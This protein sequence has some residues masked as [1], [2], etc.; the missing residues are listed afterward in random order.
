M[1]VD[2]KGRRVDKGP[3]N[4]VKDPKSKDGAVTNGISCMSCHARGIIDKPDQI[5]DHVAKNSG[6]FAKGEPELIQAIYPERHK[7]A[8]LVQ[9]DAERFALAVRATGASPGGTDPVVELAS[10]YEYDLDAELAAAEIGLPRQ[11]FLDGLNRSTDLSRV[12]G[13]LRNAG[14]TVQRAVFDSHFPQLVEAFRV[15]TM[16]QTPPPAAPSSPPAPPVE[17]TSRKP[18]AESEGELKNSIGMRLRRIERGSFVMGSAKNN[19]P[20]A[21]DEQPPHEVAISRPFFM[22][23]FEVTEEEFAL[24]MGRQ[25]PP[26]NARRLPVANV[27]RSEAVDFCQ[28][29]SLLPAEATH[30]RVYRL[31]TEAE[32]EYACRAGTTTAYPF[33]AGASLNEF[34]WYGKNS[35]GKAHPVG[36]KKANPWGLHDMLGNVAEWCADWY[37]GDYYQHSPR[38]DPTGPRQPDLPFIV[39][40]GGSSLDGAAKMRSAVRQPKLND[41]KAALYWFRVVLEIP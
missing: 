4:L 26:A 10:R 14:G 24:V 39:L 32:W 34:A 22:G 12:M 31:P 1:L 8:A 23:V 5:R 18:P 28:S 3:T 2:G 36:E 40:R 25:K 33:V 19:P 35:D 29:L 41:Y 21:D 27:T 11:A 16:L 20:T 30:G 6:A 37:E 15:G 9:Q 13:Q 7:F 38:I 17:V